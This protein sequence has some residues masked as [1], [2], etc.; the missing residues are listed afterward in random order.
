MFSTI[1]IYRLFGQQQNTKKYVWELSGANIA[2]KTIAF[3]LFQ[4]I[5]G[6]KV[7]THGIPSQH[8]TI[9]ASLNV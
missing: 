5:F 4:N 9:L 6:M 7:E 8:V 2:F 3:W 1:T